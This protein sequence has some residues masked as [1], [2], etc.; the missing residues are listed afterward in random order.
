ME[1][2]GLTLAIRPGEHACSRIDHGDDGDRTAEAYILDGLT[3]GH[4]VVYLCDRDASYFESQLTLRDHRFQRALGS[5]QLDV[6]SARDAYLP[7]GRFDVDRTIAIV[8][9]EKA[10]ALG[11]GY[12]ALRMSGEM[13]WALEGAPGSDRLAEYE[14]RLAEVFTDETLTGFCQYDQRRFDAVSLSEVA[15]PH[16]VDL[17][18]ELAALG[19]SGSLSAARVGPDQTLRLTGVLDLVDADRLATLLDAHFKE[20][21]RA[22]LAD[23]SFIDMAGIKA[24]VGAGRS[25]TITRASRPVR[26]VLEVLGRDALPGVELEEA[27]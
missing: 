2:G 20:S 14:R 9:Q 4:K 12:P 17:S 19:R 24:L 7:D 26:R 27:R 6:R 21:L 13:T 23:V 5:G 25:L 3:L 15:A 1:S 10:Q 22:D 18:S 11:E 8:W 16:D